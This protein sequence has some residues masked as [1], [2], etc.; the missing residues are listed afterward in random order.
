[1]AAVDP[2]RPGSAASFESDA[3]ICGGV[4][5]NTRPQPSANSVSAQNNA[6]SCSN[7]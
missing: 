3:H 5:S 1:V 6:S 7:Q 2:G 4:P